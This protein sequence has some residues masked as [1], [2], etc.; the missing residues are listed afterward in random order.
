MNKKIE[1]YEAQTKESVIKSWS[2]KV[3]R[4]SIKLF[5]V[6]FSSY[7]NFIDTLLT[8]GLQQNQR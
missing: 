2:I 7:E 8:A 3:L 1:E 6:K 5:S 4:Q